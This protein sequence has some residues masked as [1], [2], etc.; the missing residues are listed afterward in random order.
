MVIQ[1]E[2]L[3]PF[4]VDLEVLIPFAGGEDFGKKTS[5]RL[6]LAEAIIHPDNPLTA[7]V[8][9][10]RIWN[11]HFGKS[12]VESPSDYGIMTKKPIQLELLERLARTFMTLVGLLKVC[13][14]S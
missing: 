10:N 12:L 8:M 11:W 5:G 9:V 2:G 7:K 13:I 1:P 3:T 4:I 14:D 6:A